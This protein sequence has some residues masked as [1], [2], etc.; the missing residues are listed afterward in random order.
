MFK[1]K[2]ILFAALL[3]GSVAALSM[4]SCGSSSK[5]K[6]KG[7]A[8][9]VD[10]LGDCSAAFHLPGE[11]ADERVATCKKRMSAKDPAVTAALKCA[12]HDQCGAFETCMKSARKEEEKQRT[13]KRLEKSFAEARQKLKEGKYHSP[14]WFCTHTEGLTPEMTGWCKA[15]PTAI[16]TKMTAELV[17]ARDSGKVTWKETS[18]CDKMLGYAIKIGK[19]QGNAA[20]RLCQ[21]LTAAKEL[22]SVK[23]SVEQQLAKEKPYHPY[24][25]RLSTIK[26][27]TQIGTP[28]AKTVRAQMIELCYAKLGKKLLAQKVPK[29]KHFCWIKQLYNDFKELS[30]PDPEIRKLME[31]AAGKCEPKK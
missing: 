9:L 8:K 19:K 16:H 28:F 12:K 30:L 24:N 31:Q 23:K 17:R 1:T 5:A 22:Q 20:G 18:A 27:K 25:C 11:G 4:A 21:E 13:A 14:D 10:Q 7:C 2:Q 26:E 29:Q 3:C 15:L 6:K